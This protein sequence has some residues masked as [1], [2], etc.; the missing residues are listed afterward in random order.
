MESNNKINKNSATIINVQSTP[1]N[2]NISSYLGHLSISVF[3][4]VEGTPSFMFRQSIQPFIAHT[5]IPK[6]LEKLLKME[7]GGEESFNLKKWNPEEKKWFIEFSMSFKRNQ[8]N[9]PLI[10]I[11][12]KDKPTVK[13]TL[14]MIPKVELSNVSEHNKTNEYI[15]GLI[16]DLKFG[17]NR[18]ILSSLQ[19]IGK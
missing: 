12:A 9:K 3:Q 6:R 10:I 4:R 11:S 15:E 5:T 7:P 14:Q 17:T 2:F 16:N 13:F 8:E 1:F 18:A 19:L